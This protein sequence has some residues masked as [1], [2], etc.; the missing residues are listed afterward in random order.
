MVI[1]GAKGLAKELLTILQWNKDVNDLFFF[2]NF[3]ADIPDLLYGRFP[4]LKS[5]EALEV[6]FLSKSPQFALG[7]GGARPR[8]RQKLV[9]FIFNLNFDFEFELSLSISYQFRVN[10]RKFH[11]IL[12][13]I[14]LRVLVLHCGCVWAAIEKT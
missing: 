4:V 1:I 7:V 9:G 6:H 8:L 10:L 11:K 2:D 14:S 12:V 3:N 5:W 13:R